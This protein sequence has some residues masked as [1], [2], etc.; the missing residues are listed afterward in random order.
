VVFLALTFAALAAG[1]SPINERHARWLEDVDPL[2]LGAER[3]VFR[4]LATDYQRDA[5]IDRF[6]RERDPHPETAR[7]E[8]KERYEG[9]VH[10]AR[11]LY[12]NLKDDRARIYLIHGDPAA[13]ESIRCSGN[14]SSAEMWAYQGSEQVKYSALLIFLIPREGP[15]FIWHP[16]NERAQIQIDNASRCIGGNQLKIAASSIR[17][18]GLDWELAFQGMIAKPRPKNLEWLATF[19]AFTT[20]LPEGAS[21]FDAKVSFAH[22]GRYQHR[23]VTQGMLTVL[24]DSVVTGENLGFRSYNFEL[25]GEVIREDQLFENFRYKFSFPADEY[26]GLELPLAFQRYLRPGE[27]TLVLRLEDLNGESYFRYESPIEIPRAENQFTPP[28]VLD[29]ETA[30]LFAEATE[31]VARGETSIR[32]VPPRSLLQ[33]GLVRFETLAVGDDIE[34]VAFLLDEERL[35]AKTRPPYNVEI[36]LGEFPEP[37][38]LRV[39]ASDAEGTVVAFDEIRLN[40]AGD[41]FD[42]QL[43]EPRQDV[44]YSQ[45]LLARARVD[46]PEGASFER[47]E[48]YLNDRLLATLYQEPFAQP[49]ALPPAGKL[50]YV[51]AVGHLA[52]GRSAEDL[53]FIN[54]PNQ[55]EQVDVQMVEL[56]TT[57]LD[58]F[59]RPVQGLGEGDFEVFEDKVKQ[60]VLKFETVEDQPIHVGILFDN[61]ASMGP[62]LDYTRVAA[63]RF[64]QEALTPRDRA[65]VI[66]FNRVPRLAV[67]LTNDLR[68]LGGGL[69]GLTAEGETALYDS[70]MFG[71]YY[72]AS[73]RGQR[74]LLLLSDGKDEASRFDFDETLDYARRAGVTL[75]AIGLFQ[76]AN[77]VRS[78]LQELADETGGR[79]FFIDDLGKL[80]EVYSLI[81]E[82]LRSQ[83]V[84]TYQS[85]NQTDVETFRAISVKLSRRDLVPKTLSGYYP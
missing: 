8:L 2:I 76:Q 34:K 70:V 42:V 19:Q 85:S 7:N 31:A 63:L 71:L 83:Y 67:S 14:Y 41:R 39:E 12:R 73:V 9:R 38:T 23:T 13:K 4:A 15:A 27:Y 30:R 69:A 68:V 75:Y 21:T 20:A 53:V 59:G 60:E 55:L 24:V 50:T 10:Q 29:S 80:S 45:S 62:L 22:P 6:W 40:T 77:S 1:A 46:V 44:T 47:L 74:A 32:I 3:R 36:D 16:N 25:T 61:S 64:F 78:K 81:Q 66:T 52:D 56:Y 54:S 26:V 35:L 82:E 49:I 48:Y 51:R 33:R 57:V 18:M 17:S 37:H 65:A 72:F 11:A 28:T 5:F 79:A 58:P 43:I 84:L